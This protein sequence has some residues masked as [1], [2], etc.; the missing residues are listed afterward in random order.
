MKVCV[1]GRCSSAVESAECSELTCG[2]VCCCCSAHTYH[3]FPSQHHLGFPNVRS[4]PLWI[5]LS[6]REELDLTAAH[7]GGGE[8]TDERRILFL[9]RIVGNRSESLHDCRNTLSKQHHSGR[10]NGFEVPV[11]RGHSRKKAPLSP[12]LCFL[13]IQNMTRCARIRLQM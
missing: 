12:D 5:I 8:G 13:E 10:L 9:S 11:N 4:P 7:C 2:A 3:R 6:L 1:L